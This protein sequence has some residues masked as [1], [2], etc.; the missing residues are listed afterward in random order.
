MLRQWEEGSVLIARVC[1]SRT[2]C[3]VALRGYELLSLSD[4]T[5]FKDTSLRYRQHHFE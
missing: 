5:R 1:S 4:I 3:L 2:R